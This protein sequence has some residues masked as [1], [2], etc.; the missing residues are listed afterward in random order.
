MKRRRVMPSAP[1][2]MGEAG[3][4][5]PEGAVPHR[6]RVAVAAAEAGE[7]LRDTHEKPGSAKKF[8][9]V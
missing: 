9:A 5:Y 4:P 2:T 8:M 1:S 7:R 3:V 6:R